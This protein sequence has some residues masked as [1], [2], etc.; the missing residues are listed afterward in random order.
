MN[1]LR[2][3]A[4]RLRRRP[5]RAATGVATLALGIAA[6]TAA[7]GA[8][9][10]VLLAPLP[11]TEQDELVVLWHRSAESALEHVPLSSDQFDAARE[12][13]TA[14]VDVAAME[15]LGAWP[16]TA[17]GPDGPFVVNRVRV[18]GD[19]FG[20]LG[21]RPA[22]G[23]L[24][25]ARDDQLGAAP[26]AV[27]SHDYWTGVGRDPGL[28]GSTLRYDGRSYT[29][30]GVAPEGLDLP[31]GTDVW[32]TLRGTF[33]DWAE[34]EPVGVELDLV[35]RLASGRSADEAAADLAR[36]IGGDPDLLPYWGRVDPVVATLHEHVFGALEPVLHAVLVAA[37]VLLAAAVANATLLFLSAGTRLVREIAVRRALGAPLGR[38][39]AAPLAEAA[40]HAALGVALGVI[41]AWWAIEGLAPLA[42]AELPRLDEIRLDGTAL[43][44]A[45]LLGLGT[46][47]ASGGL[48]GLVASRAGPCDV[49]SGSG[50][51]VGHGGEGA[52]RLVAGTQIALA[53][54][55]AA[56]AALLVRSVSN[57]SGVGRGF[58]A[59]GLHVVHLMHGYAPFAVP[60]EYV[61][62]LESA[63]AELEARP[64]IVAATPTLNPPLSRSGG[65][66]M[67]PRLDGQATEQAR[68]NPFLSLDA[69]LP[70]YF[71]TIGTRIVEGR[72]LGPQDGP[73]G[74]PAV[75][76]NESA[77]R[78]LWPGE[79]VVGQR[80]VVAP[81]YPD[82]LWTVVGVVEDN[83]YR[84]FPEARPAAYLPL[85]RYQAIAP[86]RLLVRTDGSAVPL[87]DLVRSVIAET[88]PNVRVLSV[89]AMED[90]MRGPTARPRF[91]AAVLMTFA[92]VT[93][94]L[95]LLGVYGV[96][97]VLVQ[98]RAP[99]LGVRR[100]LGA[101]G[102]HLVT[103]V[104]RRVLVVGVIGVAAGGTVSVFAGRL[105][106][107][108]LFGVTP[109]DPLTLVTVL[110]TVL[111]GGLAAAGLPA[112]RA[113]RADPV[114][115][116][117]AE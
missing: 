7:F 103:F 75:V 97:A 86:S 13:T 101:S 19:F 65:L 79:P 98:E 85:A 77:A 102:G 25:D 35:G 26:V 20:V 96:F 116:L 45:A 61:P 34:E 37:L 74:A 88:A 64:G 57:L 83:R 84:S 8:V 89:D 9:Q 59:E 48:A 36:I 1:E 92:L 82:L 2:L 76:V 12:A 93:V 17:E 41:L 108:L 27:V 40:L 52:R 60:P 49:L 47:M 117:R 55:A 66:D 99:E 111:L 6:S 3:A 113:T 46:M 80:M 51:T 11:V 90:V 32:A 16:T 39:L 110:I 23:R 115:V 91:A 29:V 105:L 95:A 106:E 24:L 73:G 18:A 44:F 81:G 33:P 38:I 30:V 107:S 54:V 78:A 10:H 22:A 94:L 109:G 5:G 70:A 68:Q 15:T 56:G 69:V 43:A 4:R 62:A 63:V 71:R 31:G 87:S 114:A 67:I 58:E 104:A 100:A 72:G 21:A 50:G 112:L 42:P 53:V 28:I 14:L